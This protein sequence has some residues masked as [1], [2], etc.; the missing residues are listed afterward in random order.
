MDVSWTEIWPNAS[1]TQPLVIYCFEFCGDAESLA[2][3][4]PHGEAGVS[5]AVHRGTTSCVDSWGIAVRLVSVVSFL[6]GL[7]RLSKT[8][9]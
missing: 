7:R 3:Q 2:T 5:P 8:G 4:P 1:W 9:S 6:L